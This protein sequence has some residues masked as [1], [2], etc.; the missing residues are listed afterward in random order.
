MFEPF[1][2]TK[3]PGQGTGLGLAITTSIIDEHQG[4]ITASSAGDGMGT[5]I[6]ITLP[7]YLSSEIKLTSTDHSLFSER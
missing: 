1:F 7:L 6:K 4:T 3:D 2:T 5:H